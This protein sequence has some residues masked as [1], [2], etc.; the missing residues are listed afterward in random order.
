MQK[1]N[2]FSEEWCDIVFE[3]RPKEYGAYMLRKFSSK[4]HRTAI[5]LTLVLFLAAFTLPGLVRSIIPSGREVNVEVTNLANIDLE[6]NKKKDIVP[7]KLEEEPPV[8]IKSTIKFTPP[9]IKDDSEVKDEDIMKTQED[10]TDSKL[11]VST[12]DVKGNS[13]DA[14]AIDLADLQKKKEVVEEET[15]PYSYVEQMPEYPGGDEA[16]IKFFTKNLKYPAIAKE[17][18]IQGTVYLTFIVSKTGEISNVQVVRGIGG[19]CDEEAVRVLQLM[20]PWIPGRQNGK[21][22]PVQFTLPLRFSLAG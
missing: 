7:P 6:K 19:G 13:Q 22:V 12:S 5:I 20:P 2:I 3:G 15:K 8:K 16:R 18:G 9:V 1:I 17:S 10:L 14:D 4:R 11:S 21:T